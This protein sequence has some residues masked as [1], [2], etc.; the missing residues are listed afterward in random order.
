MITIRKIIDRV[1]SGE[2]RIPAFQRGFV[3]S[4]NQVAFLLDSIYKNFPIGTVFLWKTHERLETEKT[5]GNF[6]VPEPK[7]D[8]PIYYVLDGQ[9]RITSLFSVFQ[10]ELNPDNNYEW[11]DIYFDFTKAGQ[12]QE[13]CFIAIKS[14]QVDENIH[15]PM[16]AIFR[17]VDFHKCVSKLD[18]S[19][20]KLIT[21][22]YQKF[23]EFNL[24]SQEIETDDKESVAI[25]F[26]RINRAGEPLDT[27]QLLTAWSWSSDFDL[28]EEFSE[29]AAEMQPFG[30]G[31][32][33][34][35]KDLQ[36]KC[37]SGIIREEA[38]PSS[39]IN[40]KGE[41]VRKNFE[42][43]K[44]GIKGAVDFLR[45][46]LNVYSLDW[47]PYPSMLVSLSYFFATEKVNG[48]NVTHK[49]R[50]QLI[51]WFWRSNFSRRY[52]GGITDKHKQDIALMKKLSA[53]ENQLIAEFECEIT[54]EYFH[55]NQ[56]NIGSV[57]TKTFVL[58]LAFQNPLSFLSAAN[59]SLSDVLKTVNRNEFHHI[60]PKKHLQD[61]KVDSKKINMLA[62]FCFL[63]S[64]DNQKIKNKDPKTYKGLINPG[65][66]KNVMDRALC[67]TDSLDLTYDDFIAK[68]IEILTDRAKSII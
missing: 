50:E 6:T 40:L 5:L 11:I 56:F 51:K 14:D 66:L 28:Q 41:D 12:I 47:L 44:N 13:P 21:E 4:P 39:I 54:S 46:E 20:Q 31:N 45:N 9:Q 33:S 8:H 29:L 18:E 22:V 10:T 55:N 30:F 27:Y 48:K 53:D 67:P 7:K 36:L 57:N 43:I 42:R 3:W 34:D 63:S 61:L 37:C 68:R 25:I 32:I 26:E 1:I 35:D 62:N 17:P 49:Q 23:L 16:N 2:I 24:P 58:F 15:F 38:S 19:K 60:F 59:V 52:T 65:A 64:G